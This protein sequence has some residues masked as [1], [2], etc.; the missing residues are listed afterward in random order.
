M[1]ILYF[2]HKP[3]SCEACDRFMQNLSQ[4]CCFVQKMSAIL[5]YCQSKSVVNS[6][7]IV[8]YESGLAL[9]LKPTERTWVWG[10]GGGKVGVHAGWIGYKSI[11]S[12]ALRA[13]QIQSKQELM[14]T[15]KYPGA[16]D[17]WCELV[18][19]LST[20]NTWCVVVITILPPPRTHPNLNTHPNPITK[21]PNPNTHPDPNVKLQPLLMDQTCIQ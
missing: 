9:R 6:I 20:Q 2:L 7:E 14:A 19:M 11:W 3:S 1:F 17:T 13:V 10:R 4:E 21:N 12:W 18:I 5:C 16:P 15:L 8:M